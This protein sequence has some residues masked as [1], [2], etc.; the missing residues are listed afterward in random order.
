VASLLA[1]AYSAFRRIVRLDFCLKG[2]IAPIIASAQRI[3]RDIAFNDVPNKTRTQLEP[4]AT[5][6]E[7]LGETGMRRSR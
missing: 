7:N 3:C 2:S 4:V 1:A 6:I 5:E